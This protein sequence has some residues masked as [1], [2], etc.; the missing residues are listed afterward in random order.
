M[1]LIGEVCT[2]VLGSPV[3]IYPACCFF[4]TLSTLYHPLLVINSQL[5]V[6]IMRKEIDFL[7]RVSVFAASHF[8]VSH[9]D[10]EVTV[11]AGG[12]QLLYLAVHLSHR[13]AA[14]ALLSP[15]QNALQ[16]RQNPLQLRVQVTAV[17]Y[18]EKTHGRGQI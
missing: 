5:I 15:T 16:P 4:L 9:L 11:F 13:Q 3:F 6:F 2:P 17:V 8:L 7:E 12:G 1:H 18:M 10:G 14:C